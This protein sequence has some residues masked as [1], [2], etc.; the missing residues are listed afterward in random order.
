MATK[1]EQRLT[2]A[3]SLVE[4]L[5]VVSVIALLIALL[6]PGLASAKFAARLAVCK[7]NLRQIAVSHNAYA[8][9]SI[10]WYPVHAPAGGRSTADGYRLIIATGTHPTSSPMLA[11]YLPSNDPSNPMVARYNKA[12]QCPEGVLNIA[13]VNN[14]IRFY[15]FYA[16]RINAQGSNQKPY[17]D[18]NSD[19]SWAATRQYVVDESKLLQKIGDRMYCY[20]YSNAFGWSKVDGWY[21]FIASDHSAHDASGITANHVR[22][23]RG[24]KESTRVIWTWGVVTNNFAF[25]D[26]SVRDF[27]FDIT[28]NPPPYPTVNRGN[29]TEGGAEAYMYPKP[30]AQP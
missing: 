9:D 15:N 29:N 14:A 12:L 2:R 22:N 20:G 5:V 25:T 17:Y 26:G 18:T 1:P 6:L 19:G 24:I 21:N 11:S 3:F 7:S 27:T 13:P 10:S 23:G 8:S 16:N 30:W 4:M 28:P